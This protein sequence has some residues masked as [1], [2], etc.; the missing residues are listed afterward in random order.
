MTSRAAELKTSAN[1]AIVSKKLPQALTDLNEA[2]E[3][4]PSD[5][6]CWSN[7]SYVHELLKNHP[8]ALADAHQ[9]IALGPNFPKGYLR[10]GKALIAL[11]RQEE[12]HLRLSPIPS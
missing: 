3:L 9:C 1:K 7:R 10:A 12:A 11:N 6:A 8:A 4:A 5:I 2:V